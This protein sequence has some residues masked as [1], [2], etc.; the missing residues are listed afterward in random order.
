M[1][2]RQRALAQSVKDL[3]D[4][5]RRSNNLA[6]EI[7]A[8]LVRD[9]Q[10]AVVQSEKIRSQIRGTGEKLVYVGALK[11]SFAAPEAGRISSSIARSMG[12]RRKSRRTRTLR[13][14]PTT[15]WRSS[16]VPTN[17]L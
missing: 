6:D 7:R 15:S 2:I 14:F 17:L 5:V 8:K 1:L 4:I 9:L 11:A 10:D 16:F 13:S 12:T 3:D